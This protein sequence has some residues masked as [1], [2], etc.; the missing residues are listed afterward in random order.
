[1]ENVAERMEEKALKL[2]DTFKKKDFDKVKFEYLSRKLTEMSV[3]L[4]KK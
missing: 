2:E 1:M 3:I 4:K